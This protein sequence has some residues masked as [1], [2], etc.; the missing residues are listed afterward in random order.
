MRYPFVA[1]L[2]C[3]SL[4]LLP[5]CSSWC[6]LLSCVFY[7]AARLRLVPMEQLSSSPGSDGAA[8]L[9]PLLNPFLDALDGLRGVG[10]ICIMMY[11]FFSGFTPMAA[12]VAHYP[13]Y[14]PEFTSVVT[15]FFVISGFTLTCVYNTDGDPPMALTFLKKR[16]ARLMPVYYASLPALPSFYVYT[17]TPALTATTTLFMVQ[18]LIVPNEGW[19]FPLW[20]VGAFAFTYPFFPFVLARLR[21]WSTRA[22]RSSLIAFM[23][24]ST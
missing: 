20:Q 3:G 22:L 4:R 1:P 24:V 8:L 10:A 6:A 13:V 18:S 17:T 16:V 23:V 19:N 2:C 7:V 11:H 12:A 9:G 15:L 21:T 5:L 14:A